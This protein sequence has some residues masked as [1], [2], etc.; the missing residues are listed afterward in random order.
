[1]TTTLPDLDRL[2]HLDF[3]PPCETRWCQASPRPASYVTEVLEHLTHITTT[4]TL[5]E[6][7]L[8]CAPCWQRI[9]GKGKGICGCGEVTHWYQ[10]WRIVEVLR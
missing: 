8:V 1:M 4:A 7:R 5:G 10:L 3:E 2:E 6:L 9:R